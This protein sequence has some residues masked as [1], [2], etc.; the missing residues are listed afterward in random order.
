MR[1]EY[2][3]VSQELNEDGLNE[4]G[5]IEISGRALPSAADI[6][7][8]SYIW[9]HFFDPY[10]DYAGA[11]AVGQFS[12]TSAADAIDWSSAGGVFEEESI[13]SKSQDGLIYEVLLKNN[14]SRV[15]SVYKKDVVEGQ[16]S[17]INTVGATSVIGIELSLN[18]NSI[19]NIISIRRSSDGVELYNT[20]YMDGSFSSRVIT[21]PSDFPGG[22]GDEVIIHYNKIEIYDIDE[23]DGSFYN[24][25]ITLPSEGALGDQDLLEEVEGAYLAGED[26]YASYVAD[27][28]SVYQETSLSNLPIASIVKSNSLIALDDFDSESSNQPIFY[29]FSSAGSPSSIDRFGAAP[30]R[31]SV[32]GTSAPGKI[33]VSGETLT[34]LSIEVEAGASLTNRL[35][36]IRSEIKEALGLTT[37][38]G[39]IGIA[40]VDR[41]V[42]LGWSGKVKEEY[43]VFGCSLENIDYSVGTARIDKE[44][45]NYQFELLATP[46]N[47]LITATSGDIILLNVLIY[48]TNDYEE[49]YFDT[50]SEKITA[51][52][53]GRVKRISVSSGFR[54]GN[55]NLV[56]S[57]AVE[58]MSQPRS[59][60][61]YYVDYDFMAPKEGERITVS[62][63]VNRLVIDATADIERVRPITA[64]ILVKEADEM[65]VDVEGTILVNENALGEAD[66]IVDTA[67]NAATNQ[68]KHENKS[69]KYKQ[70][71]AKIHS[72]LMS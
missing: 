2:S 44:L 28:S 7:S 59:G 29:T 40:R 56:G 22:I 5:I 39:N 45:M 18:D 57:I 52:R 69:N 1:K 17:V 32:S 9:R 63:N 30:L 21:F 20:K 51:N 42:L 13:I 43:D 68:T 61:T 24:N 55:N 23:T 62:Y 58:A 33:K 49:V 8:V 66:R 64:D 54:T 6:L 12:D 48:N 25:A 60:S 47:N 15:L 67:I 70:L 26:V 11:D 71:N 72:C 46:N 10:I 31:L 4:S 16:A 34:R 53:F 27:T 36:D 50:A 19:E 38:P 65:L 35:V 14:I 37:I 3:V 41:A